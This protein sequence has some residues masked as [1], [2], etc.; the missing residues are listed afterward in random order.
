M[1][2]ASVTL[3]PSP[4]PTGVPGRGVKDTHVYFPDISVCP[5]TGP[6]SFKF[7]PFLPSI[8]PLKV[9]QKRREKRGE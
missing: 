6:M 3:A 7:V 5:V 2:T 4:F 1:L 9:L 8:L